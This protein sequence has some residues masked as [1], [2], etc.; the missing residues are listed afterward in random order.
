M[1]RRTTSSS[2]SPRT[3]TGQSGDSPSSRQAKVLARSILHV[4]L[5]EPAPDPARCQGS[6]LIVIFELA[7]VGVHLA[8]VVEQIAPLI[9]PVALPAAEQLAEAEA[10]VHAIGQANQATDDLGRI[11]TLPLVQRLFGLVDLGRDLFECGDE[12]RQITR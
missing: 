4:A 3:S 7:D 5:S 9:E 12:P 8:L 2:D 1:A 10:D 6:A 11:P